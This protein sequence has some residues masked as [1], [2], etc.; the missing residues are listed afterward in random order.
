MVARQN[1][2]VKNVKLY[3]SAPWTFV[4]KVEVQLHSFLTSTPGGGECSTSRP[5]RFESEKEP[6]WPRNRRLGSS[7]EPVWTFREREKPLAPTPHSVEIKERV[8][9][10]LYS[11]S[12]PSRQVIR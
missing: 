6:Q 9:L 4:K 8:Q 7:Q 10:Y 11:P 2:E 5:G 3:Q 1:T 12:V